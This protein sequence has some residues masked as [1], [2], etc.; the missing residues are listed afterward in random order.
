MENRIKLQEFERS[1]VR[2]EPELAV[3]SRIAAGRKS[4]ILR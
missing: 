4:L 2:Y 1:G 3:L